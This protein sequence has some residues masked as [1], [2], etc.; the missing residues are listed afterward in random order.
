MGILRQG[1]KLLFQDVFYQ[2]YGYVIYDHFR[3][4]AV[5]KI[6]KY[7][8]SFNIY[9]CGRYGAWEYLWSDQAILNG[10]AVAEKVIQLRDI[11]RVSSVNRK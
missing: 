2:K 3:E 7:L 6:H 10:K 4:E 9:P 8:K 11:E 5:G 1:D